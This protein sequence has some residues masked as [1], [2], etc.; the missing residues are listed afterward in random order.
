MQKSAL[1]RSRRELSNFHFSVSLHVPF[2]QFLFERDSYSNAYLLAKFGFDTSK[3]EP[4]KICPI[5]RCPR[6]G[7]SQA[8]A[9]RQLLKGQLGAVLVV[10]PEGED[11]RRASCGG[12][13]S[14]PMKTEQRTFKRK[15]QYVRKQK[16]SK[17]A[18]CDIISPE[19]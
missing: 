18:C 8:A 16:A 1:C 9:P 15:S 19:I 3:N 17:M 10:C 5:E 7:R 12:R 13:T 14:S 4:C 6:S 2:S 11:P